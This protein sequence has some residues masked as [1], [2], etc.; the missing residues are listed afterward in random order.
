[1]PHL[2]RKRSLLLGLAA[3][4]AAIG[5]ALLLAEVMLRI[6]A[7]EENIS[8]IECD[9]YLGWRGRPNI[10][11]IVH[12]PDFSI[13]VV[14][15][16][17]GHRDRERSPEPRPGVTRVLCVGG[18]FTWG[19]GVEQEALYTSVLQGQLR[20]RRP[21]WQVINVGVDGYGPDACLLYL[22]KEGLQHRPAIVI[23]Q[24]ARN[25]LSTGSTA[26]VADSI[27]AKPFFRLDEQER[28]V[29]QNSP[30]P[31][32]TLKQKLRYRA[33]R[34]SRLAYFVKQRLQA[35]SAAREAGQREDL[36]QA[37]ATA[38]EGPDEA[39]RLFCALAAEMDRACRTAG[40]RLVFL[41][42]FDF[43]R[44]EQAYWARRTAGVTVHFLPAH[45]ARR[46]KVTGIP[47]RVPS[48]GRWSQAGHYWVAEYIAE[49]VVR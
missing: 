43:S 32:M 12:E 27:Y 5:G 8:P 19:R 46:E 16:S 13:R 40:A 17:R 26:R 47:A 45:L 24:V 23:C 2:F 22:Q 31:P 6:A 10:N 35:R 37:T 34:H 49:R 39:F 9:P 21:N 4:L 44:A 41:L 25:D 3:S 38:T 11:C 28:P 48:D 1:M 42:D 33:T 15:N 7:P 29:L 14:H 36:G 30:V 18:A 20:R